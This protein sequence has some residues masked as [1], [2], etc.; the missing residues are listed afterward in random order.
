MADQATRTAGFY[1]IC[2]KG[3]KMEVALWDAGVWWTV[4]DE[5]ERDDEDVICLS[6]RLKEPDHG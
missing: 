5:Y 2:R 3:R 4:G 6:E 1:W